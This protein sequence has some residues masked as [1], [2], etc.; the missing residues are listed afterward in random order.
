MN[1]KITYFI[2]MKTQPKAT[3]IHYFFIG[4]TISGFILMQS[5]SKK[6]TS[7]IQYAEFHYVNKTIYNIKYPESLQIY[8]VDAQKNIILKRIQDSGEKV[9]ETTYYNPLSSD[10]PRKVTDPP[11]IVKFSDVKCLIISE[12]TENSPYDM[13]NYVAERIS[14]RQYKFTYTFTEADYNRAVNCP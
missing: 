3:W 10:F 11:I 6:T 8:N 13:R 9:D 2:N 5:C 14:E 1:G 12:N 4:I 7:W